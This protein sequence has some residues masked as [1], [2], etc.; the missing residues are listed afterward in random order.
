[1]IC[2]I[3]IRNIMIRKMTLPRLTWIRFVAARL[4]AA[5]P[6]NGAW[7]L[8][9]EDFAL[10]PPRVLFITPQGKGVHGVILGS[11]HLDFTVA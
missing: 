1:M 3:M 4:W 5:D 10:D 8:V 6:R 2:N 9:S 7:R 11:T